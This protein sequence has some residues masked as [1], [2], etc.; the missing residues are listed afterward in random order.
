[1]KVK[2]AGHGTLNFPDSMS[3]AEVRSVLKQFE[4]K[5]DETLPK[6]LGVLEKLLKRKPEVVTEQKLVEVEKQIV[7]KVPE[8]REVQVE[9]VIEVPAEFVPAR[10]T[11]KR[12]QNGISEVIMEPL[13]D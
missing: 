7:V 11:I 10:F 5:K 6:L 1:M 13:N 9:R 2:V 3:E 12:D 8:I 4:P